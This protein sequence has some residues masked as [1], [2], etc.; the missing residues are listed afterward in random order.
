VYGIAADPWHRNAVASLFE[1]KGRPGIKPIALLAAGIDQVD[2]VALLEGPARQAASAHWP[3]PLTVVVRRAPGLPGWLGD[4]ARDTIGVR[5]PDH[6][7]TLAL[8]EGWGRPLAA[9]SANR[10]GHPPPADARGAE[11]MLGA[12]VPLYL[13]GVGGGGASSTVVDLTGPSAVVLREGPIEW[14]TK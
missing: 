5:I 2:R 6:P 11:R 13:P 1:V 12:A 4:P 14:Q 7:V 10:S 3:G 8:L 9:T